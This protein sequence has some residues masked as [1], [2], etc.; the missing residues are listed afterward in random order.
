M[1]LLKKLSISFV[2][3]FLVSVSHLSYAHGGKSHPKKDTTVQKADS[4]AGILQHHTQAAVNQHVTEF[5]NLH[6]L[7]V[8]FPIVLIILS[9]LMQLSGIL[10]INRTYH[11]ATTIILT[12]GAV[13]GYL[14]ASVFHAHAGELPA[15]ARALFEEHE[16]WSYYAVRLS[17]LAAVIKIISLFI[18]PRKWLEGVIAVVAV[19]AGVSVA[20][21]GHHGAELVHKHGIGPKGDYLETHH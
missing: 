13:S 8:H 11:L 19:A 7:V 12:S 2:A 21:S 17:G 3:V 9:A 4:S 15:A 14:A 1:K 20:I 18:M 5:P 10:I 6:P 16:K